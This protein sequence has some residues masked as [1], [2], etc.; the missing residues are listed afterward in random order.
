MEGPSIQQFYED[1]RSR[2]DLAIFAVN[3]GEVE[4]VVA[5][6][7]KKKGWTFPALLDTRGDV[8]RT[9]RIT[10]HPESFLIDRA[11]RVAAFAVGP[12][13]WQSPY[14]EAYIRQLLAE[15]GPGD[16]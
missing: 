14:A 1:R 15:R 11:G 4:G 12:R 2:K 3:V 8:S 16:S 7:M 10:G 6:A 9:Y 13:N 5:K